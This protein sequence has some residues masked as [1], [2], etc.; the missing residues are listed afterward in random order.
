MKS[1]VDGTI[2]EGKFRN[3]KDKRRRMKGIKLSNLSEKK[4]ADRL[5]FS[6]VVQNHNGKEIGFKL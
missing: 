1:D 3:P 5:A 2:V 6:V 4:E